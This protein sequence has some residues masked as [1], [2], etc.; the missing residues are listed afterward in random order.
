MNIIEKIKIEKVY[1]IR[2]NIVATKEGVIGR[3][4]AKNFDIYLTVTIDVDEIHQRN[5]VSTQEGVMYLWA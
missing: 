2:H 5:I 4:N 1:E 3:D